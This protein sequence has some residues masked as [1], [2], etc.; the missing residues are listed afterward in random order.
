MKVLNFK[1]DGA[2]TTGVGEEV[3]SELKSI[4]TPRSGMRIMML[5][6]PT[7]TA[8]AND[9]DWTLWVDNKD[10]GQVYDHDAL[11]PTNDGGI[12]LGPRGFGIH[13]GAVVQFKWSQAVAQDNV[14]QVYYE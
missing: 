1:T 5:K 11:L 2:A 4:I 7:G 3:N 13:P 9:A 8:P 10:T 12:K 6:Q 14:L